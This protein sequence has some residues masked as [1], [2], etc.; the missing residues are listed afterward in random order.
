M[1]TGRSDF[2]DIAADEPVFTIRAKDRCAVATL[3][4]YALEAE[5]RGA[6]PALVRS[7]REHCVRMEEWQKRYG[8]KVPDL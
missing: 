3:T 5:L 4:A 7:V 2:S 8:S 1:L 6:A